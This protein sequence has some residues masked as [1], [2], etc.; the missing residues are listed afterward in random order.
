MQPLADRFYEDALGLV[1]DKAEAA[2][3]VVE[4]L[5]YEQKRRFGSP[6]S[7]YTDLPRKMGMKLGPSVAM[8]DVGQVWGY[9]PNR[10]RRRW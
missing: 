7:V 10:R 2:G 6:K 8:P 3:K 1:F 4:M 9:V 5:D